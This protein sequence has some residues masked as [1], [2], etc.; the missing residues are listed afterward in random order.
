MSKDDRYNLF[1]LAEIKSEG[2]QIEYTPNDSSGYYNDP[3]EYTWLERRVPST[4]VNDLNT[5]I[6]S[7]LEDNGYKQE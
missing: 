6:D 1:G 2:R 4:C 7:Y 5:L 3:I